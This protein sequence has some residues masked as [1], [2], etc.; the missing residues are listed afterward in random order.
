[1]AVLKCKMCGGDLEIAE[2]STIAVC[3]YCGTKQTVPSPDD[4]KKLSLF[5]RAERMRR[6]CEFDKAAGLYE[7]LAASYPKDAECFWGLVLCKFGIEYVDDPATGRKI[8]TCHRSSYKSVPEDADYKQALACAAPV[9]RHLY[10]EQAAE[11]ETIRQKIA[12]LSA[13]EEPYDVFISYKDTDASGDRTEDSVQAQNIY[14]ALTTKGYKVFFSRITLENRLGQDYEPIIFSALHSA[15]VMLVVGTELENLEAVWVK[16]EWKR[17]LQMIDAGEEKTL[18]PCYLG[19]DP[20]Y[21]L[22]GDFTERRLQAQDLGKI[23]AVQDLVRGV[24]KLVK[25]EPAPASAGG[26]NAAALLKRAE[27]AMAENQWEQAQSF[28]ER[29]LDIDAVNSSAYLTLAMIVVQCRDW[30]E[31]RTF[32]LSKDGYRTTEFV[33]ALKFDF[34]DGRVAALDRDCRE[35][36]EQRRR[37][38]EEKAE[39]ERREA[40]RRQEEQRLAAI[41]REEEMVR[42][43]PERRE[44]AQLL[45]HVSAAA[46]FDSFCLR[47]DGTVSSISGDHIDTVAKGENILAILLGREHS[48]DGLLLFGLLA[49][50]TVQLLYREKKPKL[51]EKSEWSNT[52]KEIPRWRGI[53]RIGRCDS[54]IAGL[55]RD[56]TLLL[57]KG[58]Y[59]VN[60]PLNEP[61]VVLFDETYPYAY[62]KSDGSQELQKSYDEDIFSRNDLVEMKNLF[63]GLYDLDLFALKSD[64]TVVFSARKPASG[65]TYTGLDLW[66]QYRTSVQHALAG[67]SNIVDISVW[68]S[69]LLGLRSDGT[70]LSYNMNPIMVRMDWDNNYETASIRLDKQYDTRKV[71]KLL[72]E[73]KKARNVLS[74]SSAVKGQTF[75]TADEPQ[76]SQL[77]GC[78]PDEYVRILKERIAR[79]GAQR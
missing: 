49:D 19:L 51:F 28:C 33:R 21:D 12:E 6:A 67:W 8:P 32:C 65:N 76:F 7:T 42:L 44:T 27:L 26:A 23:G 11:L 29:A 38:A 64:G 78:S 13:K 22:P 30:E 60:Y 50:G 54:Q 4:E 34:P 69:V 39:Q 46:D 66:E 16:N 35:A 9:P 71:D 37:E 18:I 41:R 3:E 56:G 72:D 57:T 48:N 15:R 70:V 17:Y 40:A 25:P 59:G 63:T 75:L 2:G 36:V 53:V 52:L 10:E 79:G 62:L 5:A 1:M 74:L 58:L 20:R 24:E 73:A 43:I 68:G 47:A 61:N 45:A 14:D 31:F 77:F 55:T